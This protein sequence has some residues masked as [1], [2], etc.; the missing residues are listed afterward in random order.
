MIWN[1]CAYIYLLVCIFN[2]ATLV[3]NADVDP[4]KMFLSFYMCN[5]TNLIPTDCLIQDLTCIEQAYNLTSEGK[6]E[7]TIFIHGYHRNK[8]PM[9]NIISAFC[10]QNTSAIALL[11]W[12]RVQPENISL[13]VTLWTP[14]IGKIAATTFYKLKS[15][16]YNVEAWHLIGHS[17]GAH[18]AGCIATYTNLSW[19]HITGLDPAGVIFYT[20]MYKGC[21][22]NPGTANL[23]DIFYTDGNG[24]GTINEVG[25]LNIYGNA[26]VAPQPGCCLSPNIQWCGHFKAIEWYADAVRNETRYSI[27]KCP[28]CFMNLRFTDY[29]KNNDHT[30]LGPHINQ[31]TNGTYCLIVD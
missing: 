18:I 13:D 31:K 9:L 5:A 8:E 16:G 11:D 15:R 4:Q 27:T 23:T 3:I 21:Q 29:C 1:T 20:D 12:T 14:A 30:Y 6:R 17:M 7:T 10:S 22:I 28:N 26:G 24:Y 19:L 2:V 25:T